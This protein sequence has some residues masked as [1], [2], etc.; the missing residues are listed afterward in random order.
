MMEMARLY[1]I[2]HVRDRLAPDNTP[3]CSF[4]S[5]DDMIQH[6]DSSK[7]TKYI[8]LFIQY[9]ML[10]DQLHIIESIKPINMA[11]WHDVNRN[12]MKYGLDMAILNNAS[13][14]EIRLL[15]SNAQSYVKQ[16]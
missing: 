9:G 2:R 5:F 7:Q 15:K 13:P 10:M 14:D 12:V 6:V 11:W 16:I 1:F 8:D 3:R 4:E